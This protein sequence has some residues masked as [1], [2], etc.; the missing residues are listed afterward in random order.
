MALAKHKKSID[1]RNLGAIF[2]ENYFLFTKATFVECE[3]P[4]D[5][6]DYQSEGGSS[7]WMGSDENG[8]FVIRASD[9]WCR[10]YHPNDRKMKLFRARIRSCT[11]NII[12]PPPFIETET[13]R[14]GKCYLKDFKRIVWRT[15]KRYIII[16]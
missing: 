13:M 7:Y 10:Y 6:A 1:P 4:K 8:D 5:T 2:H 15:K 11:W 9:H 12:I 3:K 16:E 14:C